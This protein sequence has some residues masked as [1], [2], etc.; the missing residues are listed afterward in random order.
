[1][2][3]G[4]APGMRTKKVYHKMHAR[5]KLFLKKGGGVPG[6]NAVHAKQKGRSSPPGGFPH[7]LERNADQ[8]DR[9]P[10]KS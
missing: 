6:E 9:P 4:R 1:M 2:I 10:T 8:A 5:N 7:C 3:S